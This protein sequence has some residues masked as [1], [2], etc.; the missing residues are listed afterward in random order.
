MSLDDS[1][2]AVCARICKEGRAGRGEEAHAH[3]AGQLRLRRPCPLPHT[4]PPETGAP[5]PLAPLFRSRLYIG[6]SISTS[7]QV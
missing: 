4:L 1:M 2:P 3:I 5:F 6:T 7:Q